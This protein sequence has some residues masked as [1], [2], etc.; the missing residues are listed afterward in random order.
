M[1]NISDNSILSEVQTEEIACFQRNEL[2]KA[3]RMFAIWLIVLLI[4]I[5]IM[6]FLPWSQNIQMKG[7][8][9]TF[10]PEQR[11]QD[12]NSA[13]AGRIEK[14]FVQ[15]GD[16]VEAGDTIVFLSEVK[17]EYLDPQ[18]LERAS[19]Q[20]IA[21]QGSI[22]SYQRKA[23]ALDDQ[24][25]ALRLEL[26]FKKQQLQNKIQQAEFKQQSQEAEV[27]QRE[28]DAKIAEFQYLRTDT[29]FQKGIKSLS[30]LEDKRLKVQ[31][32]KAKLITTKN[33]FQESGNDLSIAQLALQTIDNEYDNK[34]AKAQSDKFSTLSSQFEAEGT[35]NKLQNQRANYDRR[36]DMYY[37]ISP[38]SGYITKT[39]KSGIGE[40][41]KESDKI[42]TIVPFNRELAVE[43][44]VRPM[45]L[46]LMNVGQ[47]VR[48]V[49]D[50][51]QAFIISG[52]SD[53]SFGTY[54]GEVTAI[55]YISNDNSM[56]RIMVKSNQPDLTFPELLRVGAGVQGIALL[57]DVPVWYEI[58]RQ[59]NGFPPDFYENDMKK[60]ESKFKPPIK[61]FA[62]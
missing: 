54:S 11:P 51:W 38:Q 43:M 14:W 13:I 47:E 21:K 58:W 32:T 8:V 22:H 7:K 25:S 17:A 56:Y 18:L 57:H 5:L 52:W 2:P 59:L 39:L 46:P 20:I 23:N 26:A 29:L 48:L 61:P 30:D 1:L 15:E 16:L 31:S 33:K 44:Y 12:I 62:K 28:V 9:T 45:D 37:V 10:L 42:V 35:L 27:N 49:F 3:N 60:N 36:N 53:F 34:I 55:D 50:G 24:I 4:M 40:I 19:N 6:F 41:I